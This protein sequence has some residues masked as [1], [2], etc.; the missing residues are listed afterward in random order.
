MARTRRRKRATRFN[1]ALFLV[2]QFSL[3]IQGGCLRD[4]KREE[5]FP[6]R[7]GRGPQVAGPASRT[8]L[9]RV[10]DRR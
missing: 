4:A 6:R 8:G 1:L 5:G 2:H 9:L 3:M 10:S 7:T